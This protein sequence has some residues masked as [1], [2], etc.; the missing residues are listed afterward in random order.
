LE[1]SLEHLRRRRAEAQA[2]SG[3]ARGENE[4]MSLPANP[5]VVA[6]LAKPVNQPDQ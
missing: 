3:E 1:K 4:A 2:L 6:V 5:S